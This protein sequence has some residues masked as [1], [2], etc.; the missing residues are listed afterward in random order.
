MDGCTL[1]V[2]GGVLPS[3][4]VEHCVLHIERFKLAM[5]IHISHAHLDTLCLYVIHLYSVLYTG[6][7]LVNDTR[8][9]QY[10]VMLW[11]IGMGMML[12]YDFHMG[13]Y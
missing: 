9:C 3:F 8:S 1:G 10:E 13:L 7:M 4:G 11:V 5:A 12:S 6:L 2:L